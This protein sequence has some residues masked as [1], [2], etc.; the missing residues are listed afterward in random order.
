MT[1]RLLKLNQFVTSIN[2]NQDTDAALIS[3]LAANSGYI[4][5]RYH[6]HP[7]T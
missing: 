2:I 1:T 7:R 4:L 5:I 3:N 6:N